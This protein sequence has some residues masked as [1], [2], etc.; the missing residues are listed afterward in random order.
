[1]KNKEKNNRYKILII[2]IVIITILFIQKK[3]YNEKLISI[4]KSLEKKVQERTR[5]LE[6]EARKDGLTKLLNHKSCYESLEKN[7]KIAKDMKSNMSIVMIDLDYFKKVND[8]YGH[9]VGDEVLVS[10][11][12]TILNNIRKEDIAG[13]YGGEEFLIIL[14]NMDINQSLNIAKNIKNAISKIKFKYKGL[15]ITASMGVSTWSGENPIKLVN[16]ADKL[17]YKAKMNGRNRICIE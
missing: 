9:Q 12:K 13:R 7:I 11:S 2:N 16:K 10:V 3:I 15:K 14:P 1:M 8:N 17:L 6:E 5:E 4:N